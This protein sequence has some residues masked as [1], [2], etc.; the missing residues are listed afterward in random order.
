MAGDGQGF[1]QWRKTF[2]SAH[3]RGRVGWPRKPSISASNMQASASRS[4]T[5]RQFPRI[6]ISG[7]DGGGIMEA[8]KLP[9]RRP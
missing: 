9:S 3:H 1:K 6:P 5:D 2:E 7:D 4:A 8:R